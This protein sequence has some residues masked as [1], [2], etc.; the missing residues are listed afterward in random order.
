MFFES[1]PMKNA[2]IVVIAL[3]A[4]LAQA[5]SAS[6]D[7]E[8]GAQSSLTISIYNPTSDIEIGYDLGVIGVD[9]DLSRQNA[10]IGTVDVSDTDSTVSVYS[11][12]TAYGGLYGITVDN[13]PDRSDSNVLGFNSG[14]RDIWRSGYENGDSPATISAS[15]VKSCNYIFKSNGIYSGIVGG[16]NPSY[17]PSLEPLK[18]GDPV[19]IYLYQYKISTTGVEAVKANG[20]DHDYSAVLRIDSAG[21]VILNPKMADNQAPVISSA[22][23][24]PS[25]VTGGDTVSLSGVATDGDDDTLTYTWTNDYDQSELDGELTSYTA[26]TVEASTTITFTLTVNDG[27]DSVKQTTSITVTPSGGGGDNTAPVIDSATASPAT[28][29]GGATVTLSGAATDADGDTLTYTWTND[30]DSTQQTGASASYMAPTVEASTTITFTL[31]VSDGT[32]DPVTKKTGA[33]TVTPSGGGG[34]NTAPVIGSTTASPTTVTGGVTV[35]LT[36]AATDADGDTLTYTWTNDYDSTQQT[37]ASATYTAPTVE[38]STTITFT[39][40]VSDGTADATAQ[41][42]AITVNPA[43]AGGTQADAGGGQYVHAGG[44]VTLDGSGSSAAEGRAIESYVWSQSSG[45]AI[46]VTVVPSDAEPAKATFKVPAGTANFT[47]FTFTLTVT[48]DAGA[49]DEDALEIWVVPSGYHDDFTVD[50]G[51][52]ETVM[53]NASVRLHGVLGSSVSGITYTYQWTQKSGSVEIELDHAD[54]PTTTFTAPEIAI[55]EDYQFE[56]AVSDPTGKTV[57][58]YVTIGVEND[59]PPGKPTSALTDDAGWDHTKNGVL[60]AHTLRPSLKVQNPGSDGENDVLTYEFEIYSSDTIAAEN[61]LYS[62]DGVSEGD[63]ITSWRTPELEE[64]THYYWRGGV[65]DGHNAVQWMDSLEEIFINA[66]DEAPGVPTVSSP[67]DGT[68]VANTTPTLVVNNASDPDEDVLTYE[69]R[70]YASQDTAI[71]DYIQQMTD[72]VE[73]TDGTSQTIVTAALEEDTYYWWRA[74]A[75]DDADDGEWTDAAMFLVNTANS[76][77]VEPEVVYPTDGAR[78]DTHTPVFEITGGADPEGDAVEYY[79]QLDSVDTFSGDDSTLI[80]SGPLPVTDEITTW[81]PPDTLVEN[82]TYY[83]QA[84]AS[85]GESES[86]WVKGSFF[87]NQ[88]NE[89]PRQ[90]VNQYPEA[91]QE[92]TTL[93][94]TLIAKV[95][96]DLPPDPDMDS[97]VYEFEIY[98]AGDDTTPVET[99]EGLESPE[100][101]VTL[102]NGKKYYW[103]A[104]SVDENG[105]PSEEW[106]EMT[107]FTTAA[108]NYQ[109]STPVRV[110]PFDGGTVNTTTPSLVVVAADDG[111]GISIWVEF[112]LYRDSD[113][114]DF[115]S[116]GVKA[117][118]TTSTSWTVDVALDD[119]ATYYWRARATDG[120]HNSTWTPLG[121]FFVDL[122]GENS[123]NVLIQKV[124]NYD[125]N[126]PWYTV[127]SVDDTES[128]I[129]GTTIIIPPGALATYET[130]YIGT[131]T[132]APSFSDGFTPLGKV[133]EFGPTGTVFNVPVT[134]K[135]PYTDA[136]L[137]T[138][139]GITPQELKVYTYDE[140][141]GKWE[142]VTVTDVDEEA[143]LLI[144]E[145]DHFSM[146]ATAVGDAGGGDSTPG[147]SGGGGGCFIGSAART[148]PSTGVLAWVAGVL[149]MFAWAIVRS[150][151]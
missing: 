23:A 37:G 63:K 71:Y 45:D 7:F 53:E 134:I 92:I 64:N 115:V 147:A 139:G 27:T 121:N 120:D 132:G 73:G 90:L 86:S 42:G 116:S 4:L 41:T 50:A 91:M 106:S 151:P 39:L 70:I 112:E 83:Y 11:T 22:E 47:S 25:T 8:Y 31:T 119:Q 28:V 16:G 21:N 142:A 101:T 15:K 49:T 33:V 36:G 127:I 29:T 81:T 5:G 123:S 56:L 46:Q 118:S 150:D 87:V 129:Y 62:V 3:T 131:A 108:N 126:L 34:D 88:E 58:A 95:S 143:R 130:L 145:V 69:F 144:C 72:V 107:W 32:A 135:I 125:P 48:D 110:S 55:D 44:R 85:D 89:P 100:W 128:D 96:G 78:I 54:E 75:V 24:S 148:A 93:R 136:E 111:D 140:T 59:D 51:D 133:I 102:E 104:R 103:H 76:P 94:P 17:Q 20:D 6:A 82:T 117:R 43:A 68:S 138:A 99:A 122:S 35:S 105:L 66:T 79:V 2:I 80:E 40:T 9:L 13:H 18:T 74:R 114:T 38:T 30:Y 97:V 65:A 109:P 26:P 124:V 61:L 67:A 146:F 98:L 60:E 10:T 137:E 77:P 12:D 84:K 19:D 57:K 52:S 113:L 149:L 14:A 141:Q 1:T